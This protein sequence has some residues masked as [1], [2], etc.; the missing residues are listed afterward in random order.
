[1][2]L[3]AMLGLSFRKPH[4]HRMASDPAKLVD[5]FCRRRTTDVQL[6]T[7]VQSKCRFVRLFQFHDLRGHGLTDPHVTLK[8]VPLG[9]G[10]DGRD[11]RGRTQGRQTGVG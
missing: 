9:F 11:R 2:T 7:D 10:V 3:H 6:L 4:P 5:P 8:V 1:M